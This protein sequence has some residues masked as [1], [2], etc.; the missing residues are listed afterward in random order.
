L[1]LED[2]DYQSAQTYVEQF[3]SFWPLN[4]TSATLEIILELQSGDRATAE[5]KYQKFVQQ[6]P[7][8]IESQR[9]LQQLFTAATK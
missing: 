3:K 9:Y 7:A 8:E 4:P 1:L 2:G 5:M 6:F